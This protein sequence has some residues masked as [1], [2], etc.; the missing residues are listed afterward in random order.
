MV[1]VAAAV[2]AA[3]AA[4]VVVIVVSKNIHW[5]IIHT[6]KIRLFFNR[7]ASTINLVRLSNTMNV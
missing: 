7:S 1:V 3:A 2:V 5:K 4:V 6:Q